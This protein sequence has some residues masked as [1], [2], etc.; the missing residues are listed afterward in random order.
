MHTSDDPRDV[1]GY[2]LF[3]AV[4]HAARHGFEV[5][6]LTC[7]E[8]CAW[9]EEYA[10]YAA[11]KGVLLIP[12]VELDVAERAGERGRHV[13]LLGADKDAE[14]IRTFADLA[15]YRATHKGVLVI[16]PH[17]YFYGNF[18]LHAYL[19]KYIDLF[20]AIEHSWFYSTKIN[21]NTRAAQVAAHHRK[22]FIATSD[23]HFF[24]Y[25]HENYALLEVQEKTQAGVFAAITNHAFV[26]YTRPRRLVREMLVRQSLFSFTT[27]LARVGLLPTRKRK[28]H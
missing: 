23:T 22:P 19:E 24:D 14:R 25:M 20:D 7:H 4:D 3:D 10:T 21:R 12:G 5:L 16:A 11:T 15:A 2:S 13:L 18:S 28:W 6:A 8:V 1:V 26:N 17:P 9:T 27:L